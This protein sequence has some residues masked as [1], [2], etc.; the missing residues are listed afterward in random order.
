MKDIIFWANLSKKIKI[1]GINIPTTIV[2]VSKI[3]SSN[4]LL[5]QEEGFYNI[6]KYLFKGNIF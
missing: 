5:I 1:K 6:N 3:S 2:N 4:N